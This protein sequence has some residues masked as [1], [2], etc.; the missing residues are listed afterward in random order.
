[1][2]LFS[3]FEITKIILRPVKVHL[4]DDVF[5]R[6]PQILLGDITINNMEASRDSF[7]LENGTNN[8]LSVFAVSLLI[9]GIIR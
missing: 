6:A 5:F 7:S 3:K 2:D 9:E 4:I 1:M 8:V